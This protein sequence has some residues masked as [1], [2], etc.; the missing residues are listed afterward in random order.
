M[1]PLALLLASLAIPTAGYGI[2]KGMESLYYGPKK[3]KIAGKYKAAQDIEERYAATQ[4]ANETEDEPIQAGM[5]A[6]GDPGFLAF[7]SSLV[8]GG[9]GYPEDTSLLG[10]PSGTMLS[11]LLGTTPDEVQ[12]A[13]D[14]PLTSLM[15]FGTGMSRDD[16]LNFLSQSSLWQKENAPVE[17]SPP[18]GGVR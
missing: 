2:K 3:R 15:M 11:R 18:A 4:L 5:A 8:G 6:S 7:L 12:E 9:G 10:E 14:P 1:G 13:S 17:A 16:A